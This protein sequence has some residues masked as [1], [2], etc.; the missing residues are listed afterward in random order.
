M[1]NSDLF[2]LGEPIARSKDMA[3]IPGLGGDQWISS[4][5][6]GGDALPHDTL[7]PPLAA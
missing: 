2:L 7:T 6:P 1:L 5:A 3:S 4:G